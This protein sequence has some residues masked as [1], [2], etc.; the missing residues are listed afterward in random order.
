MSSGGP[1]SGLFKSTDG[2]EHW[3]EI[4]RNPGL[5]QTGLIGKIGVTVSAADSNRVY[6]LV[7]NDN[8]G[9][10]RSD[11]AGATWK[12]TFNGR[13]LRQRAF[14]YTHITADPHNK[15]LVYAQDVGTFKSTDGGQ[16]FTTVRRRRLARPLDRSGR[17]E[18]RRC[19]RATAAAQITYNALAPADLDVARVRDRPVLPRDHDEARAVSRLRRAAGQQ[20]D[21]RPEQRRTGGFGRGGRG[22]GAEAPA[23]AAAAAARPAAPARTTP[24]APSPATSRP[25]RRTRTSSSPAA[26]TAR[27][28]SAS[29][30]AR[31]RAARSDRIRASSPASPR[32]RSSS[33][34]S[35]RSRSSSRRSIR[36]CSTPARSTCGR[37]RIR[38]RRGRASARDLTRHDPK[39][40]G[41]SGGPITHD[42]N[43][44]EVYGDRLRD[45]PVEDATSTSSGRAPTTA[46]CRSRAT[47]ARRGRTSRR[48]TCRTSG[49]SASSTRRRSTRA[50]RTSR[51]RSRCSTTSRRTSSARTTTARRGRRSSP[52]SARDDYAHAVREDP[53][54]RGL[55]YAGTQHGFYISY[56]D[57]DHWQSFSLNLPDTQVCDIDRRGERPR[58]SRRTA[59]GSTSSTASG[60]CASTRRR[61]SP[62]RRISSSRTPRFGR[63]AAATIQYLL[64]KPAQSLSIEVVDPK[65]T[66]V[67]TFGGSTVGRGRR[68]GRRRARRW[69]PWRRTRRRRRPAERA[70]GH[71]AQQRHVESALPERDVVPRHDPLGRR[72]RPAPRR[73]RARTRFA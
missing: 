37:R 71:R 59:A 50:R 65:G 8:G 43:S 7:E 24:A 32:A 12:L 17:L 28:S 57:G 55:L 23:D 16:T 4:T 26:T 49:A 5:P 35:G 13:N 31:A 10:F 30:A 64:R 73:L 70:D 29:I 22:G 58:R 40:M 11:D 9:V 63:R 47:A 66:V 67:Q 52:A 48:R 72:R 46:T 44:P 42:M 41:D 56:D 25:I 3:T 68:R 38:A 60:R 61:C 39:T 45:R 15:D 51:S 21:L 36:R 14:Y 33:A 6:A 18:P 1:G 27:S 62:R 20:H 34:S 19:T 54:R 53:T 69:R 2:G